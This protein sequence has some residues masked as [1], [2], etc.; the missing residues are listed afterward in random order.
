M[1]SL[2]TQIETKDRGKTEKLY[3]WA[4]QHRGS[5]PAQL[6]AE[7]RATDKGKKKKRSIHQI[8]YS[9]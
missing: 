7:D 3:Q 2:I 5:A 6:E 9:L 4:L 8:N 1:L